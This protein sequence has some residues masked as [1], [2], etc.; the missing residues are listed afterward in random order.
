[1]AYVDW[2]CSL[3]LPDSK[4]G[5]PKQTILIAI[6]NMNRHIYCSSLLVALTILLDIGFCV[7]IR[8]AYV[9]LVYVVQHLTY[10]FEVISPWN[11]PSKD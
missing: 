9:L 6:E 3:G 11:C 8:Y 1:M 4:S 5:L 2:I 7:F 10:F